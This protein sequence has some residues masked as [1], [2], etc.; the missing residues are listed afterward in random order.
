[1]AEKYVN[2][3]GRYREENGLTWDDIAQDLTEKLGKPVQGHGVRMRGGK[4]KVPPLWADALNLEPERDEEPLMDDQP[5]TSQGATVRDEGDPPQ[6][7]EGA[8]RRPSPSPAPSGDYSIVR[9]RIGKAYAAIGAGAAM[10]AHNNGY[11]AVADL[12]KD[13]IANAWVAAARENKNV[14]R[15]VSFME[16]GGPVG[17]L[18][19]AHVILVLGFV[20]VSGRA[21]ALSVLYGNN[22]GQFHEAA[23]RAVWEAEQQPADGSGANGSGDSVA[24]ATG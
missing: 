6:A 16:S 4:G 23:A 13:D 7:P 24:Y 12:Y 18:V 17:E 21:P 2:A 14:A 1:M 8:P 3:L 9:E 10:V 11:A 22:L 15:I 20:Y 19:V 5:P